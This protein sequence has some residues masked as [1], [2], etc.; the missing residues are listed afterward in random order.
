MLS[1]SRDPCPLSPCRRLA[2]RRNAKSHHE[3]ANAIARS[4]ITAPSAPLPPLA[5]AR[6]GGDAPLLIAAEPGAEAQRVRAACGCATCDEAARSPA[7]RMRRVESPAGAGPRAPAQGTSV[8]ARAMRSARQAADV[9]G[10]RA[11]DRG[12]GGGGGL[13]ARWPARFGGRTARLRCKLHPR[14][15]GAPGKQF[16]LLGSVAARLRPGTVDRP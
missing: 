6:P 1:G 15:D 10:G 3:W 11:R 14:G 13:A 2:R 16:L 9:K 5:I 12:S 7:R 8:D 4:D